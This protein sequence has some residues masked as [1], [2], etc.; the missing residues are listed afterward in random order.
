[1]VEVDAFSIG[2][3]V[4]DILYWQ[5]QAKGEWKKGVGM[6]NGGWRGNTAYA[7]KISSIVNEIKTCEF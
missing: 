6:Y 1:M 5:A 7:N 2:E 4:K 3:G